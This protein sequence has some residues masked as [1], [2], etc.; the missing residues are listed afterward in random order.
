MKL[1]KNKLAIATAAAMAV[2]ISGQAS[3]SIYAG[4]RME[5]QAVNIIVNNTNLGTAVNTFKFT[6]NATANLNGTQAI[7]PNQGIHNCDETNCVAGPP[8]LESVASI[9]AP[10]RTSGD[11]TF[12]G[13]NHGNQTYAGAAAEITTAQLVDGAPS[14]TRQIAEV[15]VAGT[16]SAEADTTISSETSLNWTFA[17]PVNGGVLILTFEA[18]PNI[19]VDGNTEDIESLIASGE[20]TFQFVLTGANGE[21]VQWDP[22]GGVSGSP[23]EFSNCSV[24]LTCTEINDD[25]DLNTLVN[26]PFGNPIN[27]GFSDN[28]VTQPA[29]SPDW[30]LNGGFG[31]YQIEISGLSQG[32]YGVTL[33]VGA[34]TSV[35][36]TV[37]EPSSLAIV[38]LGLAG[39]G[40]AKRRKSA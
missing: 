38:G 30:P 21:N 14:N 33:N 12:F 4:S 17:N 16:G 11:Y 23:L 32:E 31:L 28:R 8:V 26:L 40:F 9:G 15:E 35:I 7:G 2:G 19:F 29:A 36:Q 1:T 6:T 22:N 37:P 27:R 25:E 5:V 34:T 10:A 3:A 18:N 39:L 24:G 20:T 13:P